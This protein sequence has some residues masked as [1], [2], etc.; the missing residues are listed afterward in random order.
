MPAS[1]KMYF[2]S[3][4]L[5]DK[6]VE[7]SKR[8]FGCNPG[9]RTSTLNLSSEYAPRMPNLLEFAIEGHRPLPHSET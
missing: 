4:A 6:V 3:P 8:V 9:L 1:N 2:A 5:L 7:G